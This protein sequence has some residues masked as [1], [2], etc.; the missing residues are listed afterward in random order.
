MFQKIKI[1]CQTTKV[2]LLELCL[3]TLIIKLPTQIGQALG[4]A[5]RVHPIGLK[6][7]NKQGRARALTKGTQLAGKKAR[8]RSRNILLERLAHD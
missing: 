6:A 2:V 4:Q 8:T 1:I 3:A 5:D 7:N